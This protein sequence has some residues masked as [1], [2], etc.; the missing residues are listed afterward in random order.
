LAE[1]KK[2]RQSTAGGTKAYLDIY[3]GLG[4]NGEAG[5]GEKRMTVVTEALYNQYKEKS[6]KLIV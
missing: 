4:A 6:R 5:A 2:Q 3:S 1:E